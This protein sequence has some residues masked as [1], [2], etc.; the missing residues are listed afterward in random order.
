MARSRKIISFNGRLRYYKGLPY[1]INAMSNVDNAI[2]LIAGDGS[3]RRD[4]ED[5]VTERNLTD[6]IIFLGDVSHDE[7][8]GLL[9]ASDIFCMPSHLRSEALG[10]SMIEAMSCGL[11]IVSCDVKSGVRFV[12]PHEETGLRV[13]PADADAL[14]NALNTLIASDNMRL[15][16]GTAARDRAKTIFSAQ[17]MNRH[18]REVYHKVLSK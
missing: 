5:L 12:N 13:Q 15:S 9:H 3:I 17:Q 10:I 18:L 14:A 16:Y 8:V 6:R 2:F 1:A 7:L 11:P 4:L